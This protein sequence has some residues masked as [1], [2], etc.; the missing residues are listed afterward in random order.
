[1]MK[2]PPAEH[3]CVWKSISVITYFTNTYVHVTKFCYTVEPEI[4]QDPTLGTHKYVTANGIKFHYV[5]NGTEGKPLMLFLHGYPE[6][7]A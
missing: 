4:L 3:S 5:A 7:C 2:H 1:M 6:V